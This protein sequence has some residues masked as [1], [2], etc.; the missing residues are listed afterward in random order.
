MLNFSTMML[1][2]PPLPESMMMRF[3]F[4]VISPYVQKNVVQLKRKPFY[5]K[6]IEV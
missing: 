3:H 6:N 4:L 1:P 5:G 2:T